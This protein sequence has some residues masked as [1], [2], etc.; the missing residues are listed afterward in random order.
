MIDALETA[1]PPPS[2][3]ILCFREVPMADAS[4]VNA[5]ERFLK[6][7][8]SHGVTVVFCE[9]R[10]G[11]ETTLAKLGVLARVEQAE[12]YEDAITVAAVAAERKG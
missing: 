7:C 1:F 9:V 12:S 3:F 6:R 10:P 4:G 8:E 5:L 2:A 11:V